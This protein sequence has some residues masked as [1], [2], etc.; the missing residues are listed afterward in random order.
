MS[1]AEEAEL[2]HY[3]RH[4]TPRQQLAELPGMTPR[5]KTPRPKTPRLKTPRPKTS[6]PCPAPIPADPQR[7]LQ[8]PDNEG[9]AAVR[10]ML[11]RR[12]YARRRS[13]VSFVAKTS[14]SPY[15]TVADNVQR[16]TRT[17][18]SGESGVNDSSAA[19]STPAS[20][21][22]YSTAPSVLV[23]VSD[24]E[25]E[26][27]TAAFLEDGLENHPSGVRV[28]SV[29]RVAPDLEHHSALLKATGQRHTL[30]AAFHG[31]T[32]VPDAKTV[33]RIA[34]GGLD[35]KKCRSARY[36][37]GAYVATNGAKAHMYAA[38]SKWDRRHGQSK[39]KHSL[40]LVVFAGVLSVPLFREGAKGVEHSYIT[41]DSLKY[42]TQFCVP[43]E[44][45]HNLVLT[46]VLYLDVGGGQR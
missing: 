24:A 30:V 18:E 10:R 21:P 36:G 17:T 37:K 25:A 12:G 19:G 15:V 34:S 38:S 22:A 33:E 8:A 3:Q 27:V 20:T 31:V 7:Q 43:S 32:T 4:R 28:G 2:K 39:L 41:A 16:G 1:R 14:S 23:P 5:P 13:F 9:A 46:H 35:P 11:E 29:R 26:T 44:L 42:P 6:T 40:P 45:P